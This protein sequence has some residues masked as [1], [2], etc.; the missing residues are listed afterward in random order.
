MVVGNTK[1]IVALAL[2]VVPVDIPLTATEAP[3]IGLLLAFVMRPETIFCQAN[4]IEKV[5]VTYSQP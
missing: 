2:V 4:K 5:I 1:S 3:R